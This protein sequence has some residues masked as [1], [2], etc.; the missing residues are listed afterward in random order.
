MKKFINGK[1]IDI[2][3]EELGAMKKDAE[4][5]KDK[6]PPSL[7]YGELVDIEIRKRYSISEEF[8]ILRQKDEKPSEYAEYYDYCEQCKEKFRSISE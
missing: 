2:T 5:N 7:S 3:A 8:A 6:T 4:K 1:Y